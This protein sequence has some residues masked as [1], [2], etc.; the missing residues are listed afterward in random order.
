MTDRL[1][2]YLKRFP[3]LYAGLRAAYQQR[4]LVRAPVPTPLGFKLAG[5]VAMQTGQFEPDETRQL[6]ALL[7]ETDVFVNVGANCGYY[8]CLARKAGLK[9]VAVEPL[10]QNVQFL[11]RN[12]LANG[13]ND[14]EVLPVGLGDRTALLKLYGGGTAASFVSGWAGAPEDHCRVVPVTTLDAV[15]ADRF[16]GERLLILI[17]VEGFEFNVLQGALRQ[18]NRHP[19]PV[20]FVEICI[21]EHQP[22]GVQANPNLMKT[23]EIFWRHGYRAEKAGCESGLVESGDV[24]RWAE[25]RQLPGTHNFL[26]RRA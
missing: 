3:L 8:V 5:P 16:A 7:G 19:A 26:F 10:D 15:L 13:W 25:G 22:G 6:S 4:Q 12:L 2:P 1:I 11:Q 17:D 23:F 21:S 18:L 20:W 24:D 9:V 14:V